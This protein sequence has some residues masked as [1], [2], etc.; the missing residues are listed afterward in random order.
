MS[1][2]L[3]AAALLLGGGCSLSV[4]SIQDL[5]SKDALDV[6][7]DAN[8]RAH[9]PGRQI[10]FFVDITNQSG[11][12]LDLAKLKVELEAAPAKSPQAVTFREDWSFRW[13]TQVRLPPGKKITVPVVPERGVEFPIELLPQGDYGIVAVVN[14]RYRSRPYPLRVVRPD[15]EVEAPPAGWQ[16]ER[17][18]GEEGGAGGEEGEDS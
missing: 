10:K 13:Q 1:G 3:A 2:G 12:T 17:R 14:D 7:L 11:R 8:A 16:A 18:G 6:G 9:L 5:S 4:V 15:L